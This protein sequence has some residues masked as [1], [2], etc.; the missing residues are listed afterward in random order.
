MKRMETREYILVTYWNWMRW[1][2]V[3]TYQGYNQSWLQA[4]ESRHRRPQSLS[5]LL[6]HTTHG[7]RPP[8]PY[9]YWYCH[10][11]QVRWRSIFQMPRQHCQLSHCKWS[12]RLL[13]IWNAAL[14]GK[15]EIGPP[16]FESMVKAVGWILWVYELLISCYMTRLA[17]VQV[18]YSAF[19]ITLVERKHGAQWHRLWFSTYCPGYVGSSQ[20]LPENSRL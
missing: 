17:R 3:S 19:V 13:C 5:I 12:H 7:I 1:A 8:D 4:Q 20:F 9:G 16:R 15:S 6:S 10:W 14:G 18:Q 2:G 11:W